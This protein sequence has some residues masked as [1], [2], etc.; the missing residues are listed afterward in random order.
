MKINPLIFRT[1]DIRGAYPDDLNEAVVSAIVSAWAQVFPKAKKIVL[2]H[3]SRL[4]SPCLKRAVLKV[5]VAAGRQVV[6]LGLAPDPLFSFSLHR[7]DLDGGMMITASHN[8]KQDNGLIL[9]LKGGAII[10]E[11]LE[12]IKQLVM[13]GKFKKGRGGGE[14]RVFAPENE[15]LDYVSEKIKLARRLKVIFDSG[16]GAMGFL[17]EKAFLALGCEVKTIFGE[18]DGRFPH[19]SPDPCQEK[20]LQSLKRVVL[21]ERA[22]LGFAFDGDGDRVVLVDNQGQRVKEDYCLLMLAKHIL[23]KDKGP[24]V[25]D[26]RVANLF[27]KTMKKMGIKTHFSV[28][29]HNAIIEK[30]QE[31]NAVFGGEITSHYFFPR[32]HYLSDDGLFSALK[33]AEIVS[34]YGDFAEFLAGLP[35]IFA[36]PEIF[37]PIPDEKKQGL[38][39]NLK[40]LLKQK[41]IEFLD[42]DGARIQFRNG[43]ALARASNTSPFIKLRFEGK[44]AKDLER[45]RKEAGTLFLEAGIKV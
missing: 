3:D 24:V 40:K 29:H 43:W 37:I 11:D 4:S 2:A 21:K 12:K 19:H 20:N 5:L 10:K 27:L 44:T 13:A 28:S 23:R 30:I 18:P 6:D 26:M 8:P 32:E 22:D 34:Q 42:V 9:N 38:I 14:V 41:K 39:D 16:N 36:T 17:A 1:Y 45:V 7:Y 31:T 25:C 35:E 33:L 15:Y